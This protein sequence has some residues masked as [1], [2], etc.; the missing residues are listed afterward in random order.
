MTEPAK[1]KPSGA[2]KMPTAS[3]NDDDTSNCDLLDTITSEALLR[4]EIQKKKAVAG[5]S[6]NYGSLN[7]NKREG[8]NIV[9]QSDTVSRIKLFM[10]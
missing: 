4:D 1:C 10:Q 8:E 7:E 9:I 3:E 2:A 6:E 5:C